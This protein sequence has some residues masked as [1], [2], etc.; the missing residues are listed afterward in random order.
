MP[1]INRK[2]NEMLLT[3]PSAGWLLVFFIIP[4]VLVVAMAFR[5][6][7]PYGGIGDPWTL[8]TFRDLKN[9]N[10]PVIIWRTI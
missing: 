7:D 3:I 2:R 5:N 4:T 6:A 10:Y 9:P 1:G 8:E